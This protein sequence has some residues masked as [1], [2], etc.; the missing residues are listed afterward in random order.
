MV[1]LGRA[2]A[3]FVPS[4]PSSDDPAHRQGP[5]IIARVR[6]VRT[7]ARPE[8]FDEVSRYR[9]L[10]GLSKNLVPL[11]GELSHPLRY[12]SNHRFGSRLRAEGY[13]GIASR[14]ARSIIE[15]ARKVDRRGVEGAIVDCGVWNGGSTILLGTGAPTR[16]V[17]AF[18]SFEGM[19]KPGPEDVD[20][21]P[22][23]EG[24]VAGSEE[25]LRE[26]FA[27]YAGR[28]ERLHVVRGWFN[29]TFPVVADEVGT[30]AALH[31]DA[32]WYDPCLLALET[33]YPR[34]AVGGIV[35]V[36]DLRMWQGARRA[37]AEYRARHGIR[38]RLVAAHYWTKS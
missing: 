21:G 33:F 22:E 17:W 11:A 26:G 10:V 38:D 1:G 31:V 19:P 36:D 34:L 24:Q 4:R 5:G 16:E 13:T 32:D 15:A 18:D 12:L 20:V 29:D 30:V 35:L 8:Q 3:T 7:Q 25:M 23:W 28:P 6:D 9:H 27:R 2:Q 14:R 37:T